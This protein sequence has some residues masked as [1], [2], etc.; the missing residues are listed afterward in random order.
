MAPFNKATK[1]ADNW[2]ACFQRYAVMNELVNE[3]RAKAREVT[4]MQAL[5]AWLRNNVSLCESPMI[6]Q[7]ITG[8]AEGER[9]GWKPGW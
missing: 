6:R 4:E 9:K 5:K 1:T 2:K 3:G 8:A 7:W